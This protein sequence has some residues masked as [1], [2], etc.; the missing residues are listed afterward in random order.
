MLYNARLWETGIGLA[1]L[2]RR[3][4]AQLDLA[5]TAMQ[6]MNRRCIFA[7]RAGLGITPGRSGVKGLCLSEKSS[8]R[9]IQTTPPRRQVPRPGDDGERIRKRAAGPAGELGVRRLSRI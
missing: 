8:P 1:A 3:R 7:D 9:C 4:H 2:K 5:A 6:L